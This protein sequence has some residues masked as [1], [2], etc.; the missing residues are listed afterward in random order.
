VDGLMARLVETGHDV[1]EMAR[2][3]IAAIGPA[4]AARLGNYGLRPAAMPSEY[5]AEA[6]AEAIRADRIRGAHI[7]IPRAQAAREALIDLLRGAGAAAVDV[8][9]AYQIVRPAPPALESVRQLI[10]RGEIDLVT[11]TSSS[12][13]SNFCAM[14][15]ADIAQGMAAAAIG[16]ITAETAR[17]RGFKVVAQPASYTVAGLCAAIQDYF[18]GRKKSA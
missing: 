2:A 5:R 12:T 17:E 18:A 6:I 9:A 7:L 10:E 13:V 3:G 16:P 4:T 11:F 14:V 1:R 15:G 8:A